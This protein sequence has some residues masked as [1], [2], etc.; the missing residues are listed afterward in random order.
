[1]KKTII[2][3]F[4]S[5]VSISAFS[6][7]GSIRIFTELEEETSWFMVYVNE[8]PQDAM[9][10]D[11]VIVEDLY[12][13]KYEL[14]VSFDSDTIADWTKTI[15]LKKGEK[16]EF[17]VVKMHKFGQDVGKVGRGVGKM[18]GKTEDDDAEDLIQYYKLE[19]IKEK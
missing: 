1:M 12:S 15:K 11:E 14:R 5:L 19:K 2:I 13:G 18:T 6:Q 17:K 4:I 9:P 7:L 8:E 3:I 10:S 16:I